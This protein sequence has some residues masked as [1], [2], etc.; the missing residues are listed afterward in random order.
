MVT[1]PKR[2]LIL[3]GT[4]FLGP[5]LVEQC[6][7]MNAEVTL[8]N[9]GRTN[10]H[11]FP[12]LEKLR[13][14]RNGDL[15]ALKGRRFDWVLDT[16]G[17][18][19][20]QVE[21]SAGLLADGA[22]RYLYVSS[23]SA[24]AEL[25]EPGASETWP[26]L[27]MPDPY[28]EELALHYGAL[29][30]GCERAAEA[31]MPSRALVVRPGL[32]VGPGDPTDRFTYWPARVARGGDIVAPNDPGDPV[33]FI[34]VRDLAAFMTSALAQ[35]RAGIYNV[36]G[37]TE[38]TTIGALLD[39]CKS[40]TGV[41]PNVHWVP[42]ASLAE[43]DVAPWMELTVWVPTDDEEFGGMGQVDIAK[44]KEAGLTTRPIEETVRDTLAWWESLP[45]Q[46]RERPRAGLAADK[47]QAVLAAVSAASSRTAA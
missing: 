44:A 25:N 37:P 47:E 13:G 27:P 42:T 32:I 14:D 1:P 33:Q 23:I 18:F 24:Y 10:P 38:R 43:H 6:L 30:A 2:V 46:R 17:Y 29:K 45:S 22:E 5:K 26:T 28:S 12:E 4:G 34:D 19:P 21:A 40:A 31:A 11:L 20:R 41:D 8:F 39:A 35:G 9:R 3:G 36:T 16:S 15:A 7:A